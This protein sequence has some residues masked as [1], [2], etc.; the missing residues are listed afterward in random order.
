MLNI[1][2][3]FNKKHPISVKNTNANYQLTLTHQG[4]YLKDNETDKCHGSF[5]EKINEIFS[6]DEN[7]QLARFFIVDKKLSID[8]LIDFNTD[9][10]F[11]HGTHHSKSSICTKL[12][13]KIFNAL[14]N[15]LKN[16]ITTVSVKIV[17]SPALEEGA[18][19]IQFGNN[20]YHGIEEDISI[21]VTRLFEN[22]KDS[23]PF[24]IGYKQQSLIAID[25]FLL[26]NDLLDA[27]DILQNEFIAFINKEDELVCAPKLVPQVTPPTKE[28]SYQ[29]DNDQITFT[30]KDDI[31]QEQK[32]RFLVEFEPSLLVNSEEVPIDTTEDIPKIVI[33]DLPDDEDINNCSDPVAKKAA[34]LPK[35]EL[36]PEETFHPINEEESNVVDLDS[37]KKRKR[38]DDGFTPEETFVHVKPTLSLVLESIISKGKY[39]NNYGITQVE[40]D[41]LNGREQTPINP[42]FIN[43]DIERLWQVND[44]I[45]FKI[46]ENSPT[47][48]GRNNEELNSLMK[49]QAVN[50]T[51]ERYPIARYGLS[52]EHL[53][54]SKK[55]EN[56][57]LLSVINE[58]SM[59][60]YIVTETKHTLINKD[61]TFK[62]GDRL[63]IG[64]FVFKLI[65]KL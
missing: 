34:D 3:P 59:P 7:G 14:S 4:Y 48:F 41:R 29:W 39:I 63:L 30:F 35:E 46:D 32:L 15:T 40:T 52:R 20:T 21:K 26:E 31:K 28:W 16:L 22:S 44:K 10:E 33:D 23:T 6:S 5:A 37:N 53:K 54:I 8:L 42:A 25:H 27:A 58:K 64:L 11:K 45:N 1:S 60:A 49:Y 2:N 51:N 13:E 61:L 24:I 57:L 50:S 12:Q 19:A 56:E 17:Y 18:L 38:H 36:P 43:L 47:L 9:K 65:K 55:N 62:E